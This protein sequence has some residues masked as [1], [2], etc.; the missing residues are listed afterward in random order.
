MTALSDL[1][2][3]AAGEMTEQ[4]A[5]ATLGSLGLPG[6]IASDVPVA[7]LSG[8]QKVR[9]ALAKLIYSPPHL[10]VLDEVTTHLD[11]DTVL[12]LVEALREFEGALLVVTHDRFF[13]RC[14]V[15]GD[16]PNE[17]GG[18]NNE[19][20]EVERKVGWKPE[21]GVVYRLLKGQLELMEGGMRDYEA[22]VSKSSAKLL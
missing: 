11:S 12:A 8:G 16:S 10:L 14:V 5:R 7:A 1:L 3:T 19:E 15:E 6:R 4:E 13:M 21:A 18:D 2:V 17:I 9:L 20:D 22:I